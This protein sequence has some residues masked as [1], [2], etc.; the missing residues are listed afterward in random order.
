VSISPVSAIEGSAVYLPQSNLNT[1]VIIRVERLTLPRNRMG[2]Y[3]MEPLRLL[4]DGRKDPN[5]VFNQPRFEGAPILLAGANFGCGSSREAAIWALMGM[6]IRCVIAPS[7]GDI[8]YSNCFQNGM[9]PVRLAEERIAKL[10]KA[11]RSGE[12][13]QVDLASCQVRGPGD[14]SFTFDIDAT[15]RQGLLLG[16]DSIDT[17]LQHDSITRSWQEDDRRRR[18]WVWAVESIS[19]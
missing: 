17:T 7:F 4:P 2:D 12:T 10:V 14:L 13:L 16:L 8:F 15:R 1:E 6:G 3:A 11:T 18:P 5:S 19:L 9:L